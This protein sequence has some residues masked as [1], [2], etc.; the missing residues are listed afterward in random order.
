MVGAVVFDFDGTLTVKEAK[1]KYNLDTLF[2]GC[3][4]I[5]NLIRFIRT[6]RE[7]QNANLYICS[8]NYQWLI[9]EILDGLH[10]EGFD[11][12]RQYFTAIETRSNDDKYVFVNSL[13]ESPVIFIDDSVDSFIGVDDSV[14][15]LHLAP[16]DLLTDP[17]FQLKVNALLVASSLSKKDDE[18]RGTPRTPPKRS[19]TTPGSSFMDAPLCGYCQ[20]QPIRGMCGCCFQVGYCGINCQARDFPR[21]LKF[22]L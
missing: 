15:K 7:K 11:N 6:L 12:I 9:E 4:R 2:G 17:D 13:K 18:E 14:V 16:R 19:K 20:V 21:H 10:K 3:E 5:L 8:R 22:Y 1:E